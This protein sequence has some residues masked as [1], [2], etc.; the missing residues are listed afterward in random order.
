MFKA[1]I[2]HFG[3]NGLNTIYGIFQLQPRPKDEGLLRWTFT[4]TRICCLVEL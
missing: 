1:D 2:M 4:Q 3:F